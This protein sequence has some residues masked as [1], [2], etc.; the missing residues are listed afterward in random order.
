MRIIKRE[1]Y[2]IILCCFL[3]SHYCTSFRDPVC[4]D[5]L[6]YVTNHI[7]YLFS[8]LNHI[9]AN[10]HFDF[11]PHS[12]KW[13]PAVTTNGHLLVITPILYFPSYTASWWA[14]S[15][16]T[17]LVTR[18]IRGWLDFPIS[19]RVYLLHIIRRNSA[20]A[21]MLNIV[22]WKIVNATYAKYTWLNGV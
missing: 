12:H 18:S 14:N 5:C 7:I 2:Y 1:S 11:T 15:V 13:D 21:Y 6:I 16:Q 3:K 20:Y 9:S 8:A 4:I 19:A 10:T 17:I 22:W